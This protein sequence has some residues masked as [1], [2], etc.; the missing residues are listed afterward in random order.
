M[1]VAREEFKANDGVDDNDEE[2]KKS[3]VEERHHGHDDGVEHNLQTC[4][5]TQP[6]S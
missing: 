6:D 3:D 1:K 4:V 5:H 2:D